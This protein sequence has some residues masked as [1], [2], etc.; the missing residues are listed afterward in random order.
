MINKKK[1]K[2]NCIIAARL[3]SKRIKQKNIKIFNGLPLI[4]HSI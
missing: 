1:I 4:A 2:P 3:G